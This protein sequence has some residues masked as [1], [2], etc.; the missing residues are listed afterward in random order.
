[1]YA[2]TVELKGYEWIAL[3]SN[4]YV[5]MR[6]GQPFAHLRPGWVPV[7]VYGMVASPYRDAE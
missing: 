2:A 1:M 5:Q 3:L 4:G 7:R 6:G